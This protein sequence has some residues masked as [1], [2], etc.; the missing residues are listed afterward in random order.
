[1][2]RKPVTILALIFLLIHP[3]IVAGDINMLDVNEAIKI[4]KRWASKN[5]YDYDQ[6]D[7]EILKVGKGTARGPV[8]FGWLSRY[9]SGK[10]IDSLIQKEFWI[11]YFYP[12]GLMEGK[13][14]LG[15][16]FCAIIDLY[17]GEVLSSFSSQ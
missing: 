4:A 16:G 6:A 7:I 13:G 1:M 8:R 17:S 15:G 5:N 9:F 11:V 14:T 12:K 2:L 10:E 3:V